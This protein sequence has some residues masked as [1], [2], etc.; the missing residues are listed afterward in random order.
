[1]RKEQRTL[2]TSGHLSLIAW[3]EGD[4]SGYSVEMMRAD[5][6][7]TASAS[8]SCAECEG[9]LCDDRTSEAIKL[10]VKGMRKV[11][12]WAAEYLP[13]DAADLF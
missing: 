12:A 7:A 3:V 8:L 9:E 13:Q 6:D 5:G 11:D 4:E 1:M 10:S 2:A